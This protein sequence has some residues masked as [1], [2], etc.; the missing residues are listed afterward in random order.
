MT[1]K[2][3]V[4]LFLIATPLLAA[5]TGASVAA[6]DD[7]DGQIAQLDGDQVYSAAGKWLGE[8]ARVLLD[9]ETGKVDYVVLSYREPRVYG[10]ALMVIDPQRFIPIPWALFTAGPEQGTLS[11]CADEMTLLPAPYLKKAPADLDVASAAAIDDYWQSVGC[12]G[13]RANFE[14]GLE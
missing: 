4:L 11:V 12:G 5:C 9:V 13:N 1:T 6:G 7:I 2:T 14:S 10:R 8:V 3:L